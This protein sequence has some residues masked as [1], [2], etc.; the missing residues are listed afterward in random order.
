M[1]TLLPFLPYLAGAALVVVLLTGP[2]LRYHRSRRRLR[3][4]CAQGR[5]T[6][7]QAVPGPR[8]PPALPAA[9]AGPVVV[10]SLCERC[11][12]AAAVD[13]VVLTAAA[14]G[15]SVSQEIEVCAACRAAVF[16]PGSQ[17]QAA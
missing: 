13:M 14:F 4:I 10:P 16:G 15:E 1:R 17:G 6:P 8:R 9:S 12:T 7:L 3:A 5:A 2:A 11:R